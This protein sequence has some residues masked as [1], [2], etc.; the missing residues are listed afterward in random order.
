M[1]LYITASSAR[2]AVDPAQTYKRTD[3]KTALCAPAGAAQRR[4]YCI[5][6]DFLFLRKDLHYL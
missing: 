2:P 3:G 6:M 4:F 1:L 5:A